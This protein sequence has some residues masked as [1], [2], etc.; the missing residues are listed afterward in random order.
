MRALRPRPLSARPFSPLG[1]PRRRQRCRTSFR[2]CSRSWRPRTAALP[3]YRPPLRLSVRCAGGPCGSRWVSAA[4]AVALVAGTAGITVAVDQPARPSGS[5][6]AA[7]TSGTHA[8][9][10]H[11]NVGE[12][13]LY[14]GS[15]S[16]VFMNV[17]VPSY[18]GPVACELEARNGAILASGSFRLVD[19]SGEWARTLPVNPEAVHV[20]LESSRP[21]RRPR[22]V[23]FG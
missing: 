2:V 14:R 21:G 10:G 22:T 11:S 9:S 4:A 16:W 1:K 13:N 12:V 8:A 23:T 18:S 6:A 5:F 15:P 20:P 19:G 3:R 7:L 17:D